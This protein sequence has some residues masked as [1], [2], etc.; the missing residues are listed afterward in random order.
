MNSFL[1]VLCIPR[2]YKNID[3]NYIRNIFS[4]LNMGE[5]ERID[6]VNKKNN[7]GD[8]YNRVFIHYRIW[9]D[10]PNAIYA[11]E[12]LMNGKDIKIMYDDLW[13]WKISIYREPDKNHK[14][15]NYKK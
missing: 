3:E 7:K 11:R 9:N 12:R 15:I 2:V 14:N 4:E 1:P 13:Y 6:I 10:T 5:L 8:N